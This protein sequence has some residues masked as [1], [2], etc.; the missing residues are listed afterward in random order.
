MEYVWKTSGQ[1]KIL[2]V[3]VK[4][5]IPQEVILSV[6]DCC[7]PYSY[8]YTQQTLVQPG[9]EVFELS[10]PLTP[11]KAFFDIRPAGPVLGSMPWG[12]VQPYG[13]SSLQFD[14]K[15]KP[16]VNKWDCKM[17]SGNALLQ[18]FL[19]FSAWFSQNAGVLAAAYNSERTVYR[20]ASGNFQIRFVPEIVDTDEYIN[21]RGQLYDNPNFGMPLPT[22]Y[23]VHVA[24]KAMEASRRYVITYTVTQ[25]MVLQVHEFAHGFLNHNPD[26]EKEADYNSIMICRCLGFSKREIGDAYALVFLRYSSNENVDRMNAIMNIL[27]QVD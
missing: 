18:D 24:T 4:S 9:V 1:P 6:R 16:F 25:R 15:E 27:R 23:R 26:D 12:V 17:V 11:E 3:A 21:I 7:K 2:E 22:S 14:M 20:S 5:Q 8:Y 10:L 13:S 19:S